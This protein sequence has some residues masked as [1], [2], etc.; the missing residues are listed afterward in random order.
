MFRLALN[1]CYRDMS[2]LGVLS[3][4]FTW[5]RGWRFG[6]GVRSTWGSN[7]AEKLPMQTLS[8]KPYKS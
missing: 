5:F 7:F 4:R 6:V 2:G 8:P 3:S 1:G